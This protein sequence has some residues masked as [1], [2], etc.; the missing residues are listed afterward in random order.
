MRQILVF[1]YNGI[2]SNKKGGGS[3]ATDK[4]N[5]VVEFQKYDD[6]W[7]KPGTEVYLL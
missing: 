2:F 1:L 4:K 3:H 6:A 5:N 7:K